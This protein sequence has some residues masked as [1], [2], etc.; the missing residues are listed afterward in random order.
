M[1]GSRAWGLGAGGALVLGVAALVAAAM[2]S[3]SAAPFEDR[4]PDRASAPV[5]VGRYPAESLSAVVVSRDLFRF[6]RRPAPVAYDAARDVQTVAVVAAPKPV[7]LLVGIVAGAEPTAV[8]EGF[9]GVEGARVVR[10]GDEVAGLKVTRIGA[11]QV[12]LAGMDTVWV[13]HV[14]EPWK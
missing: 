4:V 7:L 12:R 11:A 5:L 3:P 9:P 13:L 6:G 14:R 8:I 1:R 2:S 10:Q